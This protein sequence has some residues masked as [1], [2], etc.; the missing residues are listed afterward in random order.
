MVRPGDREKST[1]E[2]APSAPALVKHAPALLGIFSYRHPPFVVRLQADPVTGYKKRNIVLIKDKCSYAYC[3]YTDTVAFCGGLEP[4][5]L[6]SQEVCMLKLNESSY[7]TSTMTTKRIGATSFFVDGQLVV[8][9]GRSWDESFDNTHHPFSRPLILTDS[10]ERVVKLANGDVEWQMFSSAPQV[11]R[12]FSSAV[13]MNQKTAYLVG[14]YC[15]NKEFL[16]RVPPTATNT[17][18]VYDKLSG[19][20]SNGPR[21]RHARAECGAAVI[22][23]T[24]LYVAGGLNGGHPVLGIET[25]GVRDKVWTEIMKNPPWPLGP[26]TACSIGKT[27]YACGQLTRSLVSWNS[28]NDEWHEVLQLPHLYEFIIP[29]TKLDIVRR[30]SSL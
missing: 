3:K 26:C 13:A 27:I 19:R 20:W 17:V 14:G 28:E 4:N 5:Y 30:H 8:A 22:M 23:S 11:K 12:C 1:T 9:G 7:K 18:A 10:F 16:D 6:L 25:L 29:V 21:M 2:N 15:N 24:K